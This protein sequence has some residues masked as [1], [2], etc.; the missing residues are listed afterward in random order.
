MGQFQASLAKS[1]LKQIYRSG[2]DVVPASSNASATESTP[3][4]DSKSESTSSIDSSYACFSSDGK[5]ILDSKENACKGIGAKLTRAE[6][7]SF[8]VQALWLLDSDES[9]EKGILLD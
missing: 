3:P 4:G 1:T 2:A 6:M 8:V 9:K 7:K 5:I